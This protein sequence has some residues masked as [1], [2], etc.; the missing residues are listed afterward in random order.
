M[1]QSLHAPIIEY[2]D[3]TVAYASPVDSVF[4]ER[5]MLRFPAPDKY[6]G[7][8]DIKAFE[9]HLHGILRWFQVIGLGGDEWDQKRLAIHGFYLSGNAKEW[10]D[11]Q[12]LGIARSR[13]SW[14]HLEAILG[15]YDRFIDTA[16]VQNATAQFWSTAFSSDIGATGFY[17]ELK[18]AANRM[19]KRPDSYTFR[20]QFMS[21]LPAAMVNHLIDRNVTAEYCDIRQILEAAINYEWKESVSK[22]YASNRAAYRREVPLTAVRQPRQTPHNSKPR[23]EVTASREPPRLA[24]A[25]RDE[26]KKKQSRLPLSR[27]H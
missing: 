23:E 26:I 17:N 18:S 24:G 7:Q 15:L 6:S 14:T 13:R 22:R 9:G 4:D 19:I 11:T 21:R 20:N 16:C 8:S 3:E 1:D 10:Y 12:V 25:H 2:Y 27:P 5:R